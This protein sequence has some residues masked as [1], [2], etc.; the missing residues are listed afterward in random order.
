M[1]KRQISK[2][3]PLKFLQFLL[4]LKHFLNNFQLILKLAEL[5][6]KIVKNVELDDFEFRGFKKFLD[7][8]PKFNKIY[9]DIGAAD[10]VNSSCTL[11]LVKDFNWNGVCFEYGSLTK[12]SYAYRKFDNVNMCQVKVTPKN[13]SSL[14]KSYDIEKNFGF[15]NLDIDSYDLPVMEE[16][17]RSD[18]KPYI[19]S[20]EVNEKIPPPI[21]FFVYYDDNFTPTGNHFYG[22]SIS[23]ANNL[24]NQHG[25]FLNHLQGNNALFLNKDFYSPSQKSVEEIYF[26]GYLN[27]TNRKKIFWYNKDMEILEKL[28][29]NDAIGFINSKFKD[30]KGQYFLK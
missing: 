2:L 27:L 10:G 7:T 29:K 14:L 13:I 1:I 28:T 21:E 11:N 17:L 19:I 6:R 9:V 16:I 15:L 8:I 5:D 12:L 26:E 25:Y 3:L 20:M 18:Y 4:A 24:L 22:C 30:Y 23:S